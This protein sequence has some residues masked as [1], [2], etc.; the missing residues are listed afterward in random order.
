MRHIP[1][2][3]LLAFAILLVPLS[4]FGADK[5]ITRSNWREPHF[6]G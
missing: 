6:M 2:K 5:G 3:L 4:A 1:S